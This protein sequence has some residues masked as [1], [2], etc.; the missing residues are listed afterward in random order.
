MR[1]PNI[2]S[3]SASHLARIDEAAAL[4][5]VRESLSLPRSASGSL[6]LSLCGAARDMSAIRPQRRGTDEPCGPQPNQRVGA[7]SQS[8]PC[9]LHQTRVCQNRILSY[10][11]YPA[12]VRLPH[13]AGA[14]DCCVAAAQ[15]VAVAPVCRNT[16]PLVTRT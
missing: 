2:G 7:I 14:T 16:R 9:D 15:V 12:S 1:A 5:S 13:S 4:S 3:G 11:V 10:G 8:L 6:V